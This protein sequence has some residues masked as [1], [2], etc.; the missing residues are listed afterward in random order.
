MQ[1][2]GIMV[3]KDLALVAIIKC[4]NYFSKQ[5]QE[6]SKKAAATQVEHGRDF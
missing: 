1:F 3:S 5:L 6:F 4:A 2:S